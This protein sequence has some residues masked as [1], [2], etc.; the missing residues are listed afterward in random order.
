LAL[1][2]RLAAIVPLDDVRHHELRRLERRETLLAPEA[3]T[4]PAHLP[5]LARK[6]RVDDLRIGV[7]AERAVHVRPTRTPG[8][9]P[10]D[11]GRRRERVLR[12]RRKP[13][14]RRRP[15]ASRRR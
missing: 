4:A 14:L 13:A 1:V 9:E 7:I 5:A 2:E 12:R 15:Q 8:T 6:P 11:P 3:R 10:G